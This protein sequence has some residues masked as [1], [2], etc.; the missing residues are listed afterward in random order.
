MNTV[1]ENNSSN[2]EPDLLKH[3]E[4]NYNQIQS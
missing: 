2:V 3:I 1:Q 4:V